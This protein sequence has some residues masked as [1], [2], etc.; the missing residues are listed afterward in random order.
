MSARYRTGA[1]DRTLN[2]AQDR[3]LNRF[4]DRMLGGAR[5]KP[6]PNSFGQALR[7]LERCLKV[8]AKMEQKRRLEEPTGYIDPSFLAMV[9]DVLA[10]V[11]G[12]NP[13][14]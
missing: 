7:R 13:P 1:R 14:H 5:R 10:T 4:A 8:V 9:D 6:E 11:Y 2:H 12:T 3:G